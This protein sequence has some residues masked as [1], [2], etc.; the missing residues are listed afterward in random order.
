MRLA[1]EAPDHDEAVTFDRDVF[2]ASEEL[3]VAGNRKRAGAA[4]DAQPVGMT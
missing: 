3:V 1:A 2:G 4:P